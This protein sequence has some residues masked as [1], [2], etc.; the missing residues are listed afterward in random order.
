MVGRP[1]LHRSVAT[2]APQGTQSTATTPFA[3]LSYCMYGGCA[4]RHGPEAGAVWDR[5]TLGSRA[6]SSEGAF[7]VSYSDTSSKRTLTRT[8]LDIP[9]MITR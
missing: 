4:E 2:G 5:N 7:H 3:T 8:E 9:E 1:N 6:R